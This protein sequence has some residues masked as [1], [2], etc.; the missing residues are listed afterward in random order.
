MQWSGLSAGIRDARADHGIVCAMILDIDKP[1]GPAAADELID[2]AIGCD[3]ELLIGIGGDA[4]ERGV[5]LAAFAEPFERARRN[6]LRTTMHLGEEGPASDIATGVRV[7]GVERIDH[8]VSLLDDAALAAEVADRQIPVTACP[9]SNV[10]I[11]ILDRVADHPLTR[12]IARGVLATVNAD[13]A[14]MFAIDLADE[15]GNVADAFGMTLADLEALSLAGVEACWADDDTKAALRREFVADFDRLRV[16][17]GREP[18][19]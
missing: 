10:S 7:L 17:H 15:Y 5:D 14:A 4:G 13:N 9:T 18:R 1:S 12:M 3:R 16:A 6:G 11:G 19:P 8:G 2:L